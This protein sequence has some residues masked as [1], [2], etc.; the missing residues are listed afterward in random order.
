MYAVGMPILFL[1][2]AI[3]FTIMYWVDKWLV[4]RF[5][6]LPRNYD[7]STIKSCLNM[8]NYAFIWHFILGYMMI[9][10]NRIFTTDQSHNP[11]KYDD[12]GRWFNPDRINTPHTILF[13]VGN[14]ILMLGSLEAFCKRKTYFVIEKICPCIKRLKGSLIEMEAVSDDYYDELH[15]K[16]LVNE[17]E[18]A[19]LEK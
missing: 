4:L 7:E 2:S 1:I 3:N 19:K 5:Y 6:R 16:F 11:K 9:S 18:R 10:N 15:L 12:F 13:V 14:G 17:Y 8:M